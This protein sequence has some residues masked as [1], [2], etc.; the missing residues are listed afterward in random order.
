MYGC[1][2]DNLVPPETRLLI[3]ELIFCQR[4]VTD[5]KH[6]IGKILPDVLFGMFAAFKHGENLGSSSDRVIHTAIWFEAA[7]VPYRSVIS[8]TMFVGILLVVAAEFRD[9]ST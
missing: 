4:I 6:L 9:L 2:N 1:R 5:R 7:C 8:D 3:F